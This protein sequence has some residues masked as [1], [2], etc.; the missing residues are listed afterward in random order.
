LAARPRHFN[1]WHLHAAMALQASLN[2][3]RR[4]V[5]RLGELR[6]RRLTTAKPFQQL[7]IFLFGPRFASARWLT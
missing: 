3:G 4:S 6:N 7:T 2:S 1:P 5:M